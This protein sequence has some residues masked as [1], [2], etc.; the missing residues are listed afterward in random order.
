[1]GCLPSKTQRSTKNRNTKDRHLQPSPVAAARYPLRQPLNL[2]RCDNVDAAFCMLDCCRIHS[3][4]SPSLPDGIY[5]PSS[6][7]LALACV[8]KRRHQRAL[9]PLPPQPLLPPLL[10][11]CRTCRSRNLLPAQA[12]LAWLY[13]LCSGFRDSRQSTMSR[14]RC[15][16][17]IVF[18]LV[19][20]NQTS[21]I[22]IYLCIFR[23][24]E[25]TGV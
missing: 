10:P 8:S 15:Y 6:C 23:K 18:S 3:R 12:S 4:F 11:H 24:V 1:M 5:S 22:V 9:P 19:V 13:C 14:A 21:W 17:G 20:D 25:N 7:S 2:W 16:R